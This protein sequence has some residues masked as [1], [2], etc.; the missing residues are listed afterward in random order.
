MAGTNRSNLPNELLRTSDSLALKMAGFASIDFSSFQVQSQKF[1]EVLENQFASVR[2]FA[3]KI[4]SSF[5]SLASKAKPL[6]QFLIDRAKARLN[7]LNWVK[8]Y[9]L[10]QIPIIGFIPIPIRGKPRLKKLFLIS[11]IKHTAPPRV[12]VVD[13]AF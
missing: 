13:F 5:Q 4:R 8:I 10:I 2:K 7:R 6:I 3:E 1:A 9:S 12:G 11:S